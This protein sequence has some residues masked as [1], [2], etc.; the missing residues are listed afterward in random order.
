MP[1]YL[2]N[3]SYK[4]DDEDYSTI[5]VAQVKNLGLSFSKG[6]KGV[7]LDADNKAVLLAG[8]TVCYWDILVIHEPGQRMIT[9]I[10]AFEEGL[11]HLYDWAKGNA[12]KQHSM[13]IPL[14]LITGH[15][16][17]LQISL[18][19]ELKN[20][21]I[22]LF[23]SSAIPLKD[24]E[25][26][27][28]E[29]ITEIGERIVKVFEIDRCA[30][31]VFKL[32]LQPDDY[33]CGVIVTDSIC[34][35]LA[36]EPLVIQNGS[37]ISLSQN[38]I[39]AIRK[40]HMELAGDDF[41]K[42]QSNDLF[43]EEGKLAQPNYTA[44]A[45]AEIAIADTLSKLIDQ[46]PDIIEKTDLNRHIINFISSDPSADSVAAIK[47]FMKANYQLLLD[48]KILEKIFDIKTDTKPEDDFIW[49]PDG[50]KDTL[51]KILRTLCAEK[52][53]TAVENQDQDDSSSD[54]EDSDEDSEETTEVIIV[55]DNYRMKGQISKDEKP[56]GLCREKFYDESLSKYC[57]FTGLFYNGSKVSGVEES[58]HRRF[59]IDTYFKGTFVRDSF[60]TGNIR[61]LLA[62]A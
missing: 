61:V 49:R 2:P 51:E 58:V 42:K 39:N 29:V 54:S 17:L 18:D 52:H 38:D 36:L 30:T 7:V 57:T 11:Q 5:I 13:Q 32:I 34:R 56:H 37:G 41:A 15:W 62:M 31:Q 6:S 47:V 23:D 26:D 44:D 46:L 14:N 19:L 16:A 53:L 8:K 45:E 12:P 50:G 55:S 10:N 24:L 9:K 28:S 60:Q 48:A 21:T 27:L 3:N 35:Q 1:G 59:N 25:H 4:Y 40:R 22:S 33:A 20:I 43:I